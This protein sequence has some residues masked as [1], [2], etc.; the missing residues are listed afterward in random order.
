M[1][2]LPVYQKGPN[3]HPSNFFSNITLLCLIQASKSR[4]LRS[5]VPHLSITFKGASI[6]LPL[7][8]REVEQ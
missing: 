8:H 4:R 3:H 5:G 2:L 1:R 7:L 6:S